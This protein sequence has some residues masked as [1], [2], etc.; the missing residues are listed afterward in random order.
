MPRKKADF[1]TPTQDAPVEFKIEKNIPLFPPR[2]SRRKYPFHEMEIGD[3]VFL[4][5]RKPSNLGGST[6]CLAPKKFAFR[7]VEG[8]VR[9]W[10]VA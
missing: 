6:A 7:N 1:E 5:D 2:A 3:S 4:A 10:R 8:G 9:V